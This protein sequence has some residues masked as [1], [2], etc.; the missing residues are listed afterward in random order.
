M[1]HQIAEHDLSNSFPIFFTDFI[2]FSIIQK[3]GLFLSWNRTT[4]RTIGGDDNVTFFTK[5][6]Q[7]LL[8]DLRWRLDLRI[9]FEFYQKIEEKKYEILW[10]KLLKLPDSWPVLCGNWLANDRLVGCWNSKCQ[11]FWPGPSR[12]AL[13]LP[14]MYPNNRHHCGGKRKMRL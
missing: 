3:S 4:Q 13:P 11:Y 14:S 7:F 5:L 6:N 12:Q 1:A 2:Q 8:I 9:I 10:P